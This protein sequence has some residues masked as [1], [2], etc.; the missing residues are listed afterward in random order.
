MKRNKLKKNN[1]INKTRLQENI[2]QK[3]IEEP[4][5]HEPNDII[6][7]GEKREGRRQGKKYVSML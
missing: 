1:S 7:T 3:E 5:K 6:S 4:N 2:E